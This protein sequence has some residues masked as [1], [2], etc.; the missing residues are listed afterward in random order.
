MDLESSVNNFNKF[1]HIFTTLAHNITT[2]RFTKNVKFAFE[3]YFI[4]M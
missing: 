4:L 3:I 1:K 2:I